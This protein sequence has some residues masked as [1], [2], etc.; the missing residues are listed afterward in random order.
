MY[1]VSDDET[2]SQIFHCIE[3]GQPLTDACLLDDM[4]TEMKEVLF[5]LI[6]DGMIQAD[7]SYS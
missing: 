4:S 3:Q 6:D 2:A 5:D 7:V 1:E